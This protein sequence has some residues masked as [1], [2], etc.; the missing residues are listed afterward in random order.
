MLFHEFKRKWNDMPTVANGFLALG[1]DHPLNFQIGHYSSAY[2]SLIVMD[3]GIIK[4]IPSSF[5]V[6]AVNAEL[7][8]G[9]W[10]LEFQLVHESFEEEYLRLCWDM[11][12]A[13]AE[14][15]DPLTDF[16]K[17]YLSW[18]KLLQYS[19]KKSMSFQ[20]QKGLLGELLYL[21]E[22]IDEM[23]TETAVAAWQGP[24]GSDQDFLFEDT[25]T[26]V[27]SVA[28][29]SDK[30]KI[31]SMQQL[32][33]ET[34][35]E[36]R[37]Y[38]MEKSVEG[39]ARYN[40]VDMVNQIEEKLL[41]Q[42]QINDHFEMKLFKYGYREEDIERYRQYYF[43]LIELRKY[44]VNEAFPKLTGRNTDS[45]VVSCEYELSFPGIEEF[46]RD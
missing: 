12:E 1:L 33:Q 29:A 41:P 11:I 26:E 15:Q 16:I 31:S 43:R 4:N 32:D 17:K 20:M 7:K 46:R 34:D 2:K 38:V 21:D 18:Q 22:C 37:V 23:G 28:L 24:D 39:D 27:K 25:W 14:S 13:S 6:H 8:S 3:T 35:G 9:Q 10:I 36:L 5:A 19:E 40:L 44:V 30:V 42:P 45:A